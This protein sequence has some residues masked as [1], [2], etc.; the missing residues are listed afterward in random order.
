MKLN[1]NFSSVG[2]GKVFQK[3]ETISNVVPNKQTILDVANVLSDTTAPRGQPV[4][5]KSVA[6][7]VGVDYV[8]YIIEKERFDPKSHLWIKIDEFKLIG[9]KSN[10]FRDTRVAYGVT[11]RYRMKSV[12]KATVKKEI[13]SLNHFSSTKDLQKFVVGKIQESLA[14]NKDL[15]VQVQKQG[16]DGLVLK[17]SAGVEEISIDISDS[18]RTV[19]NADNTFKLVDSVNN[20]VLDFAHGS[21][22][23]EQ[24]LSA[25]NKMATPSPTKEFEYIS[26]YY[27]SNPSKNWTVVDIVKLDPPGYPQTIKISPNSFQKEVI[28]SWLKPVSDVEVK[29]YNVYRRAKINEPWTPIA[30]GLR[31]FETLFVDNDV[32]LGQKYIY[33]ISSID[34]HGIESF[35]SMQIQVEMNANIAIEKKEKDLVCV[36]GGGTTLDETTLILKKFFERKEQLIARKNIKIKPNTKFRDESKDFIIRVKSLDT[37]EQFELKVTLRN[38]KL[39]RDK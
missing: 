35:L 9:S 20:Q 30:E 12:L 5:F 25:F 23:D 18:I 36:S 24:F 28:I 13:K 15:L 6:A 3:T 2:F 11:Y 1:V 14:E 27:E 16:N 17:S 8:G 10:V 29:F 39:Q 33:A 34:V 19:L 22:S 26:V 32:I 38:Q 31:E 37:H 21:L 7:L 4:E